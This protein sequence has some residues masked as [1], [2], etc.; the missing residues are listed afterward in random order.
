MK[1]QRRDRAFTLIEL[2][3][4]TAISAVVIAAASAVISA[5]M[6]TFASVSAA[7]EDALRRVQLVSALEQDLA[8]AMP[9][10]GLKFEGEGSRMSFPRMVSFSRSTNATAIVKIQWERD[11]GGGIVRTLTRADKTETKER[12]GRTQNFRIV[13]AGAEEGESP[14]SAK[15]LT[16]TDEWKRESFPGIV[17]VDFGDFTLAS[18]VMCSGFALETEDRK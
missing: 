8:S 11:A 4:A 10:N 6:R 12:F 9:L 2:L 18:A 5:G 13:Y 17:R 3:I 15:T 7:G 16:W 14:P 1:A